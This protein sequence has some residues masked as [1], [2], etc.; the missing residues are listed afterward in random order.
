MYDVAALAVGAVL[1]ALAVRYTAGVH[2]HTD[3]KARVAETSDE[4]PRDDD[5]PILGATHVGPGVAWDTCPRCDR[6]TPSGGLCKE[7][8]DDAETH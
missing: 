8:R 3:E 4:D 1:L 7:C 5:A 2:R 6:P